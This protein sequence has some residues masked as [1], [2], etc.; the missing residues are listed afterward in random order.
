LP[1]GERIDHADP[2]RRFAARLNDEGGSHLK[3]AQCCDALHERAAIE[4]GAESLRYHEF[5][6][7]RLLLLLL[8]VSY[9]LVP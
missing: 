9:R 5:S 1:A 3:G 4:L 7:G 8:N 6:S 2:D